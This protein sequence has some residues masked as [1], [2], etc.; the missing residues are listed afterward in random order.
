MKYN[1]LIQFQP[2]ES[3]IELRQANRSDKARELVTTYVISEEMADRLCDL[4]IPQLQFATPHDNRGVLIVGN[5][6]TGKS[7]LMSVISSVAE[8]AEFQQLLTNGRVRNAASQIAGKFKVIR[9]E[10]GAVETGLRDI[11]TGHLEERLAEWGIAFQFPPADKIRENKTSFE[12]M[13]TAFHQ[14]FPNHGLLLV[15]DELLD[16][17]RSR[18]DQQLIL[19]LGLLREI[20]EVCKDLRFRFLAGVQEAIFDSGRFAHVADSLG[21]VKDRFQQVKIATA[22][23]TYVVANRLLKKEP[24]QAE[25]IRSYLTP[26]SRFYGN[27]TERMDDYTALFPIHP[28]YVETFER[29]PI[30]EKRGVLQIISFAIK[31]LVGEEVPE[32]RPGVVAFDSYWKALKENA[33]HRA[34]PEVK[35][36]IDCS[37]ALEAKIKSAFPKQTYKPMALR[38]IAGLSVH[39]LTTGDPY[40][41]LGLTPEELRDGLCLFHPGA[42]EMGGDPADDL[43]SVVENTLRE[44][45]KTVSGQ[46]ISANKDNRQYYLD[47][48]KTDDYDAL[49]ERRAESLDDSTLDRYYYD[50]LR[51]AMESTDISTHITGFQIWQHEIEWRDHKA[52]RLGYLFFGSPNDRSTAI[53]KRDFYLYFIQP[54]DPPRYTDEKKPDEVFF[55]LTGKDDTFSQSLKLYAAAL[56]LASISSGIKKQTYERKALDQLASLTKWLSEHLLQSIEVTYQGS[57]K[58]FMEWLKGSGISGNVNIRDAVNAV[59]AK[60]LTE[61]FSNS[62]PEYP[63]FSTLVT[64]GRD[65]NAQQAAQEAIRGI[66]Q[67]N[68]TKQGTAI[69]DA[70][71]LL[72]GEKLDPARSRYSRFILDLLK[73]KG[74]GQVVNR[75]EVIISLDPG[76]EYMAPDKF[77]LEPIWVSVLLASLVYSGDVVLAIPGI[78]FDASSLS[79]LAATPVQD[80][81][82]FK[83]L[84]R[85][86]DWNVPS[87]KAL[88]ELMGLPPGMAIQV[89]RGDSIAVQ[90][91]HKVIND[92]I[93]RLVRINQQVLSGIPFWGQ[94]LFSD[95]E[96]ARLSTTMAQAKEFLESLQAYNTPG[97]L[98]NF[99][100]DAEEITGFAATFSRLKEVED[101]RTFAIEHANLTQY[102]SA[103]EAVL[104]ESSP[105]VEDCR[106]RRS[107]VLAEIRKPEQRESAHFKAELVKQ[108]KKLKS[109]YIKSYLELY[110][111]A[112]LSLAQDSERK[113]LLQDYRLNQLRRLA[114]VEV[115]NRQ[116][117]NEVDRQLDRLKTGSVLTEKDLDVEPRAPDGFWPSM[118]DMSVSAE[119]RLSH[120]KNEL[121]RVHKSWTNSLLN[122][123]KDPAIQ[124]NFDLLKLEQKKMLQDFIEAKELPDEI[125]QEF[126]AAIQHA[127]SGLSK[128]TVH[129]DD[130]LK[131]LFP[132]GGPATPAE[133]KQRFS[134]YLEQLLKGRDAAKVRLA[135]E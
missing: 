20:G 35:S 5:Y 67:P 120:L 38:I 125:S 42:A 4:V 66:A 91:L 90:Q 34:L 49:V 62:A 135:I 92:R 7:H 113:A 111:R 17:L 109:S 58:K 15:I 130:L 74:Q 126:L 96:V 79:A 121:G 78:K 16:Y 102:L 93:E 39:R 127:L 50:A 71:E 86:R 52:G 116:Q 36:I 89:T 87:L 72:D 95:A 80:L 119:A 12:A 75:Q 110:R 33:A 64:Y 21:R 98:K 134:E 1:E 30:V 122:D 77:R 88:F 100:Y 117:L 129:I 133:F 55:R 28:D 32:D 115:I 131:S 22:D 73:G 11:I 25:M 26:F 99:K 68:R 85:P 10:I 40:S 123:L 51:Q 70:L 61:Q 45:H 69:L 14:K 56:E 118:E 48:K 76:V 97:K 63:R 41:P 124:S 57:R 108:L 107:E 114:T 104:P 8:N 103:A 3:V 101:L 81:Q 18:R 47:L 105:W 19:D 2:I 54:F 112:R 46:F 65:G 23:V 29:I 37:D 132:D 128:I 94:N 43:L 60:C 9:L 6:G 106:Y 82:N 13:M 27:M 83:H 53:P 59:A 84:E 31:A 24:K 44:I